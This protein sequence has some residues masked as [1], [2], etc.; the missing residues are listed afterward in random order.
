MVGRVLWGMT[1]VLALATC[2]GDTTGGGDEENHSISDPDV[3]E[4]TMREDFVPLIAGIA[5]GLERL[6]IAAAGGQ[7]DGVVIVPNG[8]G[9]TATI[10]MDFDGNGS[11]EASINGTLTG[12]IQTGAL[13]SIAAIAGQEPSLGGTGSLTATETSPGIV[14]LDHLEGTGGADPPGS[15]NSADV[16]VTDGTVAVDLVGGVLDGFVEFE[17]VGQGET[18]GVELSFEPNGAGGYVVRISGNGFDFTI[19]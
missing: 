13:V 19:P 9:A 5:D 11:R 1:A 7:A 18:L 2:K 8:S 6:L 17:V 3:L 12:D 4:T 16:T 10:S 15:M 14:L